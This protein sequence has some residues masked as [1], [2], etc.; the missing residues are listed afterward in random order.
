MTRGSSKPSKRR[1]SR[2]AKSPEVS[3][4]ANSGGA[5][6]SPASPREKRKSSSSPRLLNRWRGRNAEE[7]PA[8]AM[9]EPVPDPPSVEENAGEE[10]AAAMSD[11]HSVPDPP[12]PKETA[13]DVPC[14]PK[15]KHMTRA[16]KKAAEEA[17][18]RSGA[19]PNDEVPQ[20]SDEVPEDPMVAVPE[21]AQ[22]GRKAAVPNDVDA[23]K[24]RAAKAKA[25]KAPVQEP[26]LVDEP[27]AD[28]PE[29]VLTVTVPSEAEP[30]PVRSNRRSDS[31]DGSRNSPIVEKA[32]N[33]IRSLGSPKRSAVPEDVPGSKFSPEP[34][35]PVPVP[36]EIEML[37]EL[38]SMCYGPERWAPPGYIKAIINACSNDCVFHQKLVEICR[39]IAEKEGLLPFFERKDAQKAKTEYESEVNHNE[40]KI[41][42]YDVLL[43]LCRLK[44]VDKN[45]HAKTF[46]ALENLEGLTPDEKKK[47]VYK[48]NE[49]A[50]QE[51]NLKRHK[52]LSKYCKV[53][54]LVL[55]DV[56]LWKP[57]SEEFVGLVAKALVNSGLLSDNYEDMEKVYNGVKSGAKHCAIRAENF[58]R[59][60]TRLGLEHP[61]V[62][63]GGGRSIQARMEY[64]VDFKGKSV[65]LVAR[66]L[67]GSECA[68]PTLKYLYDHFAD[69]VS[70]YPERKT[71]QQGYDLFHERRE[72]FCEM[73]YTQS[74]HSPKMIAK[75]DEVLEACHTILE[76]Y[77]NKFCFGFDDFWRLLY[78]KFPDSRVEIHAEEEHWISCFL[79]NKCFQAAAMSFDKESPGKHLCAKLAAYQLNKLLSEHGFDVSVNDLASFLVKFSGNQPTA[80]HRVLYGYRGMLKCFP[81]CDFMEPYK[82]DTYKNGNLCYPQTRGLLKKPFE[83]PDPNNPDEMAVAGQGIDLDKIRY[84]KFLGNGSYGTVY[85]VIHVETLEVMV[86]KYEWV[87]SYEV[88][89]GFMRSTRTHSHVSHLP[90]VVDLKGIVVP[91]DLVE[92]DTG[93]RKRKKFVKQARVKL[94]SV[95][96]LDENNRPVSVDYEHILVG[97][98]QGFCNDGDFNEYVS[99][100]A[101]KGKLNVRVVCGSI[102]QLSS[103]VKTMSKMEFVHRDIKTENIVFHDG[104]PKLVDFN[105]AREMD[106]KGRMT[107]NVG[108][109]RF[110]SQA[111]EDGE[112]NSQSEIFGIGQT[113]KECPHIMELLKKGME[114]N[115]VVSEKVFDLIDK[116]ANST[117]PLPAK[118]VVFTIE[119]IQRE[120]GFV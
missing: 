22:D 63:V 3:A 28:V 6:D 92:E 95:I 51:E 112:Y 19:V 40:W 34:D 109:P 50:Q 114:E 115:D 93:R 73:V 42:R 44:M 106:A 17:K 99:A 116:M 57:D 11:P 8:A 86:L 27:M 104:K 83:E 107:A 29:P 87:P 67:F 5:A 20:L 118:D 37:A 49:E 90:N 64:E 85:K 71:N 54:I 10:P 62:E 91:F 117:C 113:F 38:M 32:V 52:L 74:I 60:F 4:R 78:G 94:L 15:K 24:T 88:E 1:N 108:T 120:H 48:N 35:N 45:T 75:V 119:R 56:A 21:P 103:T 80:T 25:N 13:V 102:E 41:F 39:N 79:K 12:T 7:E 82:N 61:T 46:H 33:F 96:E 23:P 110:M 65:R 43:F 100:L 55:R 111:V 66:K 18:A 53:W 16:A 70:K 47:K 36:P 68:D 97:T 101:K 77:E 76:D 72:E 59:L 81:L 26:A 69:L 58:K 30:S 89:E 98:F 105:L 84:L 2:R 14:F 31:V 9:P